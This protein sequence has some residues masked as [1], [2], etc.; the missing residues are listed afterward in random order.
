MMA[1]G[2]IVAFFTLVWR[3]NSPIQ[4]LGQLWS[5]IQEG[6]GAS[7]RGFTLMQAEKEPIKK[8]SKKSISF[9]GNELMLDEVSF[10]YN[11][12]GFPQRNKADHNQLNTNEQLQ[13][14]TLHLSPQT[15]TALVGPSG[16]GKSTVAKIAAGLLFPTQGQGSGTYWG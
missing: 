7:E 5:Q 12:H 14:I 4:A 1:L 15:F 11:E 2:A 9:T 13:R 10:A 6:L 8:N 3:V 16:S